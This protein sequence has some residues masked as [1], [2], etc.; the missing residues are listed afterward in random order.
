VLSLDAEDRISLNDRQCDH[1]I[2][3]MRAYYDVGERTAVSSSENRGMGIQLDEREA[4]LSACYLDAALNKIEVAEYDQR[5][6][7]DRL[8]SGEATRVEVQA[9]FE[10]MLYAGV[11][12]TD[13]LAEILDRVYT[14]GLQPPNL[15]RAL[16]ALRQ[17]PLDNETQRVVG[18]L[19]RWRR[20]YYTKN[21]RE[22]VWHYEAGD[23]VGV[24]EGGSVGLLAEQYVRDLHD[25][26]PIVERLAEILGL[27]ERLQQL[28]TARN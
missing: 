9:Y 22:G 19:N 21:V 2:D 24:D 23:G 11:A 1:A 5:R 13:Q 26:R 7:A 8:R 6:L 15:R 16:D 4:L 27:D 17:R 12:A 28:R 14:L 20:H 3:W 10:G 25:L 18:D